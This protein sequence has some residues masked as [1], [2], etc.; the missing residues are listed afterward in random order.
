MKNTIQ[1]K[2][3]NR[4]RKLYFNK[5]SDR[6]VR[7]YS[8]QH[9]MF[10]RPERRGYTRHANDAGVYFFSDALDASGHCGNEKGICYEFLPKDTP[11]SA[12]QE[13][14]GK[15]KLLLSTAT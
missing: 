7:I 14:Q 3:I 11:L 10:W 1:L 5:L 9:Q 8:C 13:A 12:T 2:A 6:L 4:N 15:A